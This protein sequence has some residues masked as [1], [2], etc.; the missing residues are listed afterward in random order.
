MPEEQILKW[1]VQLIP[2]EPTLENFIE[3]FVLR[4][5]KQQLSVFS[6]DIQ[7]PL[8][9]DAEH[10]RCP[11]GDVD[12]GLRFRAIALPRQAVALLRFGR[13]IP[14]SRHHAADSEFHAYSCLGLD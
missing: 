14:R 7:Q 12:G 3:L 9:N 4:L 2:T 8:C 1:P 5:S 11:D 13:V 10:R 6:L